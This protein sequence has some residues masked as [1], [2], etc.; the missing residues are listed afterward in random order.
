MTTT[1]GHLRYG[2]PAQ[3]FDV[4]DRTLAHIEIVTLAKLRRGEAFAL[5]IPRPTGGR[6]TLWINAASMLVFELD[7]DAGPIDRAWLETL[8]D[9]ANGA[10][11][12]R[13]ASA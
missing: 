4:D 13:L 12:L 3:T 7:G 10:A 2:S 9:A 5:T 1:M 6:S 11:G 8:I